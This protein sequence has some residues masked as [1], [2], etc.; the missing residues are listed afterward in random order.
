METFLGAV[1]TEHQMKIFFF[2]MI[3]I[4]FIVIIIGYSVKGR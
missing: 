3:V 4:T 2:G 1:V